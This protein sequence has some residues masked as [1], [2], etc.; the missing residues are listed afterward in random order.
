MRRRNLLAGALVIALLAGCGSRALRSPLEALDRAAARVERGAD[1]ADDLAL[2]AWHAWLVRGDGALGRERAE[3]ALVDERHHPWARLLLAELEAAAAEP[4]AEARHLLALLDGGARGPLAELAARRL[5]ALAGRSLALDEQIAARARMLLERKAASAEVAAELRAALIEI[6]ARRDPEAALQWADRAGRL[7]EVAVVGPLSRYSFL[8]FGS[9]RPEFESGPL[10][11]EGTSLRF[12]TGEISLVDLPRDGDVYYALAAVTVPRRGTYL[13]RAS[14]T[15]TASVALFL[16]G[17]PVLER[18]GWGGP[19]PTLVVARVELDEGEHLL[20]VRIG[21]GYGTGAVTVELS[22]ADGSPADLSFRA[23]R[24]G[25]GAARRGVRVLTTTPTPL[26][27][28]VGILASWVRAGLAHG[29]DPEAVRLAL[30]A[31]VEELPSSPALLWR[32]GRAWLSDPSL[33]ERVRRERAVADLERAA[34]GE[35]LAALL[36][37]AALHRREGRW[38]AAEEAL[39]RAKELAPQSLALG[40]ER[41]RYLRDRGFEGL[42]HSAAHELRERASDRCDVLGLAWTAASRARDAEAR[43]TLAKEAEACPGGRARALG[44]ARDAGDLALARRLAESRVRLAPDALSTFLLRAELELAAGRPEQAAAILEEAEKRFPW[45]ALL[46]RSRAEYLVAAGREDL[47]REARLRAL[48]L[49]GGDLAALRTEAFERRRAILAQ[50]DPET[51]AAIRA[52]EARAR[53]FDAPGVILVDF[54]GFEVHPDGSMVERTHVLAKILD[55]RGIEILGEVNLPA[56]AEVLE[57]RTIKSDGT[58]LEPEL[59]AAKDSISFPRLEVGD[60]VEYQYLRAHGRRAAALPGWT[61]PRFFFASRDLPTVEAILAVRAPKELGLE[62]DAHQ[63]PPRWEV[64]DEGSHQ[65]LL[66]RGRDLPAHVPEP[67]SV[68]MAEVVPWIQV[69]AGAGERDGACQLADRM[70]GAGWVDREVARWARDA[71]GT[72]SPRERIER[73]WARLMAEIE[74]DGSFEERASHVLARR[75]GNRAV[76]LKAALDSLGIENAW[77]VLRPFDRNPNPRRFPV[78]SDFTRLVL[79]ARPEPTGGW[80]WLDPSIRYARTGVL[81]PEVQGVPGYVLGQGTGVDACVP[82]VSPVETTTG[83][84]L[85]Y[86]VRL[87]GDGSLEGLATETF[88]GM[89]AAQAR[90]VFE[91]LDREHLEQAVEAALA[92][93]FSGAELVDLELDVSDAEV[94]L[95]YSFRRGEALQAMGE[96]RARLELDFLRLHLAQR[97]LV[98]AERKTPLLLD[99]DERLVVEAEIAIPPGWTIEVAPAA[100]RERSDFGSFRR[101]V[102]GKDGVLVVRDEVEIRRGRIPPH[103]Y[104]AFAAWVRAVDRSVGEDLVLRI[105]SGEEPEGNLGMKVEPAVGAGDDATPARDEA[106]A[107]EFVDRLP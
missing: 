98:V 45:S 41:A 61:A 102:G 18:A 32:R 37:L 92:R 79:V 10:Q 96:N 71:A 28:G 16:D 103:D 51:F 22:P 24:P 11:Q 23:A 25:D 68:S 31:A 64:I 73:L 34:E 80:L 30:E 107:S 53:S 59:I 4:A 27:E 49:D 50:H 105:P 47:A 60:Y 2:A 74:G 39:G 100:A 36:D 26:P 90:N 44:F 76:L 57:L 94:A 13:V 7:T 5:R 83:R 1:G 106:G 55:K 6:E 75:R 104:P 19:R 54:V 38:S 81:S 40:V 85:S 63:H 62:V 46:P 72:G 35:I 9:R 14:T 93:E 78:P 58:I 29:R 70:L 66:A 8:E 101:S 67:S 89:S 52:F 21:K 77:V 97:Y 65:L 15:P 12:P 42:F 88:R 82:T 99:R 48:E 95:S 84:V 3:R 43:R 69:G 17:L 87:H 56:D 33:P 86:R 91:R 20:S